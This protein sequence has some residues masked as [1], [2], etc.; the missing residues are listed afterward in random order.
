ME[1]DPKRAKVAMVD[2]A[3]A[4]R[5]NEVLGEMTAIR[6]SDD[7]LV[8]GRCGNQKRYFDGLKPI[9]TEKDD[10]EPLTTWSS[11]EL[12]KK[13]ALRV[14]GKALRQNAAAKARGFGM[15]SLLAPKKQMERSGTSFANSDKAKSHVSA[16]PEP[17]SRDVRSTLDAVTEPKGSPICVGTKEPSKKIQTTVQDVSHGPDLSMMHRTL[18][19]LSC[20]GVRS[21]GFQRLET[22]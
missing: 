21:S 9:P 20:A 11:F 13:R 14:K 6:W 8:N 18:S 17:R 19:R 22:R 1:P 15:E 4:Q 3:R 16:Q 12:V 10:C 5:R 2:D 7:M